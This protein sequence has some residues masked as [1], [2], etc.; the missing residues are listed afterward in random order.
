[1]E[2]ESINP[3]FEIIQPKVFKISCCRSYMTTK[4]RCYTCPEDDYEDENDDNRE[5][6]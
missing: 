4:G 2:P 5:E 6:E 3:E 1:M